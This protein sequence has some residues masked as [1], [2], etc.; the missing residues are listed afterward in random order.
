MFYDRDTVNPGHGVT[1]LH[2]LHLSRGDGWRRDFQAVA[3]Y[4]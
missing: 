2:A 1:Y 4:S 3:L